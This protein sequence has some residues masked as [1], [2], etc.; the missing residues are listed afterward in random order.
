[1]IDGITRRS[2]NEL[3]LAGTAAAGLGLGARPAT[4]LQTADIAWTSD[5]PHLGGNFAPVGPEL[6]VDN[7]PVIAGRIPPGLSG[8]YMR[9]GPNPL[10]KPIAFTLSLIHI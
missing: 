10:F 9:N 4:A 6:D 2:F 8:A 3:L 1:M 7:L 5:D